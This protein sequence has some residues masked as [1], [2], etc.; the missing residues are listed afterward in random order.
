MRKLKYILLF[1]L[2]TVVFNSCLIDDTT[3]VD[4]Y[5]QG[6]N[7][8]GF[9]LTAS[10]ISAV[11]DGSEYK[12]YM[13]VKLMGPTVNELQGDVT[14][15]VAADASSTAIEG[16]HFRLDNPTLVLKKENNYLGLLEVTMVTAGVETPLK[17]S[18]ILVLKPTAATGESKVVASGKMLAVTMNYACPSFLEG[19]Y[20][21]VVTRDGNTITPYSTVTITKTGVGEYRTSEVGHWPAASLGGTPGFTFYDVCGVITVPRQNLVDLYSNIVQ[22]FVE[23]NVNEDTGVITIIYKIT[24][25][26]ESEYVWVCT[27]I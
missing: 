21:V 13:K 15:T 26:W 3:M 7:V 4:D 24:S 2:S 27:P 11:A 19:T 17:P 16:T 23:G 10:T 18:P 9:E 22:G 14:V 25:T 6:N 5:D 8:A 12:F 1:I 20:S